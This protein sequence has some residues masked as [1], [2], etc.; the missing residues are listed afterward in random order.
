MASDLREEADE[1]YGC[2]GGLLVSILIPKRLPIQTFI[3]D[4]NFFV[5]DDPL[6]SSDDL[7]GNQNHT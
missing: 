3:Q 7:D 1:G 6:F 5:F 2:C 4:W